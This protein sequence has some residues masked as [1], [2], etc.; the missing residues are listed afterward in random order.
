VAAP[1]VHGVGA[2]DSSATGGY[3]PT[4]PAGV[5]TDDILI[6]AVEQV[7]GEA[8]PASTGYAHV[9]GS[10]VVQDTNTQL[11]VLWKRAGA[12]ESNPTVTGIV[13]HAMT[14]LITVR[15]CITTGNPWDVNSI[16]NATSN[17]SATWPGVT[18]TVDEC[19][20]LE[21]IATGTDT[22]AAQFAALIT[23]GNYSGIAEQMDNWTTAGTGGGVAMF[24]G[25]KATAGATG[26]ST[27]TLLTAATKAYMTL[28]LKPAP[29]PAGPTGLPTLVAPPPYYRR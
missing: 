12:S 13:N 11:S 15:G 9:T 7:G 23:N 21:I 28:A 3:V 10:P 25:V 22:T 20:V 19:L 1:T 14:R 16:A 27:G 29:P 4:L 5:A 18:T 8:A 26:Q 2:A 17:T 6:I 24:S